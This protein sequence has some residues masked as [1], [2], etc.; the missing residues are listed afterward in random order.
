MPKGG[1]EDAQVQ[2]PMEQ[3]REQIREL[4]IKAAN[5]RAPDVPFVLHLRS[6]VEAS[7][8][9]VEGLG[10]D[11]RPERTRLQTVDNLLDRQSS[12]IVGACVRLGGMRAVRRDTDPPRSHWWWY[13]DEVVA[14]RVRRNAIRFSALIIGVV[15]LVLVGNYIL[16]MFFG[17]DPQE[18]EAFGHTT[19]AES[20]LAVG[21]LE[22]AVER[23]EQAVVVQP[24]L[25]EGWVALAVLY[26]RLERPDAMSAAL[27]KAEALVVDPLRLALLLARQYEM[28]QE[29]DVALEHAER[30]VQ[31]NPESAEAYLIRG[32]IRDSRGDREQA[33]RD[34]ERASDLAG[35]Q[36]EAAI[37]VLARTRMG[38]LLQQGAGAPLPGAD[39]P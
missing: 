5:L 9:E 17:M 1:L 6:Q 34:F 23:Y 2:T 10:R 21:D 29:Y 15:L 22:G 37:L 12:R 31:I 16:N 39:E 24:D 14:E 8:A 38:M 25:A 18:Q 11:L 26:D 7:V 35:A 4:E 13:L 27:A 33:L 28:V 30:A 3:V 32:G 36:G 20:L 19:V